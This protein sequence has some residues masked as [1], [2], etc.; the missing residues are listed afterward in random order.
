VT[1]T[2][3]P[4][5]T[6]TVTGTPTIAVCNESCSED[7]D[8]A[9]GLFCDSESNRCRK[10]A[11]SDEKDCSCPVAT[12]EPTI[13]DC[14]YKCNSD[15][16]CSSGLI[17]DSDSGRCRKPACSDEKDCSCPKARKTDAP[18]R[19]IT[20]RRTTT[21]TAAQPTVLKEA[22]ILDFPGAAV[23]GSGLLLTIIGILLAL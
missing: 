11:C 22:G 18:T 17:C 7:D 8:C 5:G 14:N 20:T 12:P 19:E 4:T 16:N 1:V 2:G 21:R 15:D 23:F 3:T 13:V 6:V 9:D 10:P